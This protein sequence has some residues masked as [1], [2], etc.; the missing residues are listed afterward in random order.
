MAVLFDISHMQTVPAP[1]GSTQNG[2]QT[3]NAGQ[4]FSN[5]LHLRNSSMPWAVVSDLCYRIVR[6]LFVYF[7]CLLGH[8]WASS[9]ITPESVLKDKLLARFRESFRVPRIKAGENVQGKCLTYYKC[10]TY[11]L[12]GSI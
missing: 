3:C 9:E 12:S 5:F 2:T 10:L 1:H 7:V 6:I 8:T 11:S 4:W